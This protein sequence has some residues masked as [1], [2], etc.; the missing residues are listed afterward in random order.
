MIQLNNFD[1]Y[2]R[3]IE[4]QT[5]GEIDGLNNRASLNQK[6]M[7]KRLA[8]MFTSFFDNFTRE[9]LVLH[10]SSITISFVIVLLN[11]VLLEFIV[12][13]LVM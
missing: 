5:K 10:A 13:S 11:T 9:R 8:N 7:I 3:E 1:V 4:N 6:D 2:I 12:K